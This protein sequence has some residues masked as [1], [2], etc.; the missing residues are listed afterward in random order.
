[1]GG[2]GVTA[3]TMRRWGLLI[4]RCVLAGVFLWA[5][6]A[7]LADPRAFASGIET[8]RVLPGWSIN[9]LAVSAPILEVAAA[10]LLFSKWSRQG[11]L[12]CG[13]LAG[14]FVGLFLWAFSQGLNVR[15]A[16]FGSTG[17]GAESVLFGLVRA[18][19]LLVWSAALYGVLL[20]NSQS[21]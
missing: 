11:A 16:C 19:F 21:A 1:M 12:L 9:L 6:I 17:N 3:G 14:V 15:C 18:A 4:G 10:F 8:F 13:L 5:G 7:K 2:G 20:R